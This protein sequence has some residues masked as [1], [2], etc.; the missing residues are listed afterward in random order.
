LPVPVGGAFHVNAQKVVTLNT[1]SRHQVLIVGGGIAG[2]ALLYTLA[3]YTPLRRVA[4]I[5][6]A[7]ALATVNSRT[8]YNSQTLHAGDIETNYSLDKALKVR[9]A[10]DMIVNFARAREDTGSLIFNYPKMVLGVGEAECALIRQRFE[11]FAPHYPNM[12]LLDAADIA[13]LEPNA[14][15]CDG[16]PRP[17]EIA[18]MGSVGD[19]STADFAALSRAFAQAAASEP[20][21]EIE[22]R[23]DTRALDIEHRP[24]GFHVR[25]SRGRFS[26][27]A[28]IVCAGAHSLLLAQRMG[29]GERFSVLP[30]AGSFYLAPKLLNGKVYTVQND[31]LPFAAVHGDPDIAAGGRTRF[32]PTATV[33][34][35]LERHDWRSV[36]GFFRVFGPDRTLLAV[37]AQLLGVPD[38]RRYMGM[39][40][41]Y[42]LPLLGR[43]LFL[44]SARKIVP[45]LRLNDLHYARGFGG[46]R[47]QLIDKQERRLLMGEA[48][49]PA[50]DGL[51]FNVTPSP[52]A[53][54]CLGNAR[55]DAQTVCR[56][57]NVAFDDGRFAGELAP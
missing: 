40:L 56:Y 42:D 8:T 54:S 27:D 33:V 49:I 3:R 9:S 5:E 38:I 45:S 55:A 12:R 48:S 50:C 34:P 20:G 13:R 24:D 37:Y 7:S 19:W 16:R 35:M 26:A 29:Y 44:N 43:R 14:A 30:V 6:K 10:V 23:L 47:P 28:L 41:L 18:A 53:T 51:I 15:L 25:T 36:P 57:L 22:V 1:D 17:G 32:G 31:R 4:L 11:R 21:K 46:L 39:N 2:T 52:G